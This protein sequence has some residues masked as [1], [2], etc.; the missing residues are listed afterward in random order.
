MI[1]FH[2][3]IN[4]SSEN[5]FK[6][7]INYCFYLQKLITGKATIHTDLLFRPKRFYYIVLYT[8]VLFLCAFPLPWR[9]LNFILSGNGNS[10]FSTWMTIE[11]S[12]SLYVLKPILSGL[13]HRYTHTHNEKNEK[14]FLHFLKRADCCITDILFHKT[15]VG[16][17]GQPNNNVG[18]GV[19]KVFTYKRPTIEINK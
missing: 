1:N 18:A 6:R 10:E 12:K 8:F 4:A 5:K 14:E 15:H 7:S 17:C 3:V 16:N 19:S 13:K 9:A 2:N 11:C